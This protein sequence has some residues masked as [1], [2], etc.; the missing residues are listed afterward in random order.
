MFNRKL[1]LYCLSLK[2][3]FVPLFFF[4]SFEKQLNVFQRVLTA[5]FDLSF[6]LIP[7]TEVMEFNRNLIETY[8]LVFVVIVVLVKFQFQLTSKLFL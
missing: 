3:F 4:C 8:L 5:N 7:V 1:Y 2:Y 6:T